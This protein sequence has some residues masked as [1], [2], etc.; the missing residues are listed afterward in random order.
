MPFTPLSS[1]E[2][3]QYN[4]G[5]LDLGTA[6]KSGFQPFESKPISNPDRTQAALANATSLSERLNSPEFQARMKEEAAREPLYKQ[7][8][9]GFA[10]G[11]A[12][13]VLGL[14]QLGTRFGEWASSKLSKGIEAITG[15]KVKAPSEEQLSGAPILKPETPTGQAS[16]SVL[17]AQTPGEVGGKVAE[18]AAEVG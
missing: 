16:Q 1:D 17:E 14:G 2:L 5:T 3:S 11:A 7:A 10:K 15:G 18:F 4:A 12:E 8:A 9:A 6:Q 13:S